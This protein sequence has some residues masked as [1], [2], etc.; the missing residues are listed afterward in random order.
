M[1]NTRNPLAAPE[2]KFTPLDFKAVAADGAFEGYASLFDKE[3]LGHD[4]IAPGAFRASLHERGPT[5]IKM[6]F[7]HNPSEPIGIPATAMP[8]TP[9]GRVASRRLIS[10]TGTW[11][12]IR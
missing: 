8:L 10:A 12:S 3:D 1:R 5:G 6:L 2:L 4:V 7:Q 9:T 11:P